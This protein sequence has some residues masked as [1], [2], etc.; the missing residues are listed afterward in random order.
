MTL[1]LAL[2]AL[3]LGSGATLLCKAIKAATIRQYLAD[4][5]TVLRRL[6]RDQRDFRRD[7]D[8]DTCLAPPSPHS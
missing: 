1:Q 3:H 8:S 4:V 6:D 2:F 5:S 7:S